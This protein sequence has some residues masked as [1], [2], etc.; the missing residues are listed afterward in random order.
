MSETTTYSRFAHGWA[1]LACRTAGRALAQSR[2]EA[3]AGLPRWTHLALSVTDIDAMIDWYTTHTPLELLVK[4]EDANGYGAWLGHSDAPD[5]PFILVFAQFFAGHE[6]DEHAGP[7]PLG[8][9]AHLGFEVA[10][11]SDI[12]AIAAVAEEGGWLATPPLQLPHP[13][14]YIC[15]VRD[16]DGNTVEFSHDQ[17]VYEFA[18][19][20]FTRPG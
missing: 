13:I 20:H 4:R 12:D 19:E 10:D 6:P 16:P 1:R 7:T 8:S 18:Q 5:T 9:F 2:F 17:G 15:M 3:V 14:G 11:R